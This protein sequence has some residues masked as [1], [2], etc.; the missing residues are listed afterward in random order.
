MLL[1]YLLSLLGLAL[2]DTGRLCGGGGEC[3]AGWKK[4]GGEECLLFMSGWEE[5]SAREVCRGL[6]AQYQ[7]FFL[8][9][10]DSDS[11]TRHSLPVCLLRRETP[12]REAGILQW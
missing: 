4:V 12:G 5:A 8:S 3:P 6:R 2:A 9:S 7:E 10:S 11:A 1:L